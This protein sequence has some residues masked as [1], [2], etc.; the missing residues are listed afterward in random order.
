MKKCRGLLVLFLAAMLLLTGCQELF[1]RERSYSNVRV[2]GNSPMPYPINLPDEK[3]VALCDLVMNAPRQEISDEEV[4]AMYEFLY[5]DGLTVEFACGPTHYEWHFVGRD[6]VSC[7]IKPLV[8]K[9]TTMYYMSEALS[10]KVDDF[11]KKCDH[12]E[13][14]A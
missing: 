14:Q 7:T 13:G 12:G 10:E 11:I 9:E 6:I 5:S 4:S 2:Y 3:L 8:G 1:P